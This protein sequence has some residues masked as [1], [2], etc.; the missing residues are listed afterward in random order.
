MAI[1][2]DRHQALRERLIHAAERTIA[3]RGLAA[4]RA[5][6]LAREAG[7]A[8]GMIYVLFAHLD[9]LVLCVG[10]RTL[11]M[12]EETLGVAR[13]P[14]S[15]SSNE[16]AVADLVRLAL[17]YLEFAASHTVRWRALFEHRM[18]QG[19]LLP[20]WYAEQLRMLFVQIERPLTSLLPEFDRHARRIYART[21]FSAVHGN[22]RAGPRREPRFPADAGAAHPT[23][24]HRARYCGRPRRAALRRPAA[25]AAIAGISVASPGSRPG[26][27]SSRVCARATM[28][29]ELSYEKPILLRSDRRVSLGIWL[30]STPVGANID[31]RTW[32]TGFAA[33]VRGHG[34][35]SL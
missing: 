12:L 4:L 14:G 19:R 17:V 15:E 30:A 28:S 10:S 24:C 33:R 26:A 3:E 22:I 11:A 25:G 34:R 13:S 18:A 21:L 20:E 8:V 16:G 9:E 35:P 29:D 23:H 6:D 5:R 7:R 32:R 2:A 1:R 31:R 27:G